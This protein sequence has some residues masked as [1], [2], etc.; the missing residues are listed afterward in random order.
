MFSHRLTM[1][2]MMFVH[3][4]SAQMTFGLLTAALFV[5]M[6]TFLDPYK[7]WGMRHLA[8]LLFMSLFLTMLVGAHK[9]LSETTVSGDDQYED[10]TTAASLAILITSFMCIVAAFGILVFDSVSMVRKMRKEHEEQYD[11]QQVRLSCRAGLC[12]AVL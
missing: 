11:L 7:E 10:E 4:E 3:S 1:A 6:Q 2:S 5:V 12:W 8:N 9:N